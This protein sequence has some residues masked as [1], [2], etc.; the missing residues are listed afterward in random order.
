MI[1]SIKIESQEDTPKIIF[2]PENEIFEISGR[3]LPEDAVLFYEPILAWLKEY[4]QNPNPVT[5]MHVKLNYFN[6]ASSKLLLDL[7]MVLEDMVEDG[8]DCK[9]M[10]FYD[11]ED[12]DMEEAGEEYSELIEI[13]FELITY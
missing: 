11:E 7:L 3:S 2:D 4:S 10:W 8:K 9:I 6:T 5:E 12:E 1:N 13:P